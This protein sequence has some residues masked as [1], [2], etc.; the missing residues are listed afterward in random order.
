MTNT[1]K[2]ILYIV[3]ADL[4]SGSGKC[5]LELI[6]SV[7]NNTE[8]EPVV[9]TQFYNELNTKC[10]ELSIE[11]YSSHFARTCSRGMGLFGWAI[12]FLCRPFLNFLSYKEL[13]RKIDFTS[14]HLIHSNTSAI[15]FGA[16]LY[17]KLHIP[18]IWH[19]REFLIFNHMLHPIVYNLPKYI[20]NNSS[21]I[22]TVSNQLN[23]FLQNRTKCSN[24][25]TI[26]DGV[27]SNSKKIAPQSTNDSGKLR[28]VCVGNLTPLKG[29]DTLL[30]AV[31]LLSKQILDQISIDFYGQCTEDFEKKLKKLVRKIPIESVVSFKGYCNDIF[32]LLADYDI[33]VQ[34]SH[35]E[36]FSRVTVE[37]ML[38]GLCVIGNGDTA[39]QELI[40][41]EKTGLL[42][43]DYNIQS[44]A[45]KI[46]YC[47]YN[48]DRMKKLGQNA[49]K[50][51]LEK[52]CI[53]KNFYNIVNEYNSTIKA[54]ILRE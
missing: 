8:F 47:F 42:Y 12:A 43:K 24:I 5:A 40:E 21:C 32:G 22:I 13:K 45:D 31:G 34:P 38:A 3:E 19:I 6:K 51:A 36:G 16:Y 27:Y 39:I 48:R 41:D 30:E 54:N 14:L 26:Y 23:I 17:R 25:K 46:S 50:I 52:Y 1:R 4:T 53:E 28:L 18:H 15:D 2:K 11:N 37:Y 33:G 44:F 35:T 9:I 7:K 49:R 20:V 29:Q 10:N